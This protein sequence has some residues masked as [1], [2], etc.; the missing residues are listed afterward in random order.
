MVDHWRSSKISI[1]E[2]LEHRKCIP[3]NST[4]TRDLDNM[5]TFDNLRKLKIN[6]Y[7]VTYI[8]L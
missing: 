4:I 3:T 5:L 7:E 2:I 8:I 1:F 6:A